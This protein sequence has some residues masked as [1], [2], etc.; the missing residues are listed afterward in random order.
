MIIGHINIERPLLLAPMEGVTDLPF[1]LICKSLG[2]D[3]V[4]TEF[5]NSEGLVRN[6]VKTRK[7][8]AFL[9]EER[10]FGI[11]IYG[12]NPDS[13]QHAAQ[14]AEELSGE[15]VLSFPLE[16]NMSRRIELPVV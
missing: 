8:M 7:K 10:P 14:M 15:G 13:M 4:Y 16:D 5:V 1:R 11:Q 9:E 6:S 12:G 3:I 2:A